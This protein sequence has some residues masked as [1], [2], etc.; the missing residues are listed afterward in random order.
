MREGRECILGSSN[1]GRPRKHKLPVNPEA[2][3]QPEPTRSSEEDESAFAGLQNPSDALG[4][5]A[6][7]ADENLESRRNSLHAQSHRSPFQQH[8][9][10]AVSYVT[11][12]QADAIPYQLCT[13]GYLT[14]RKV[15][16]LLER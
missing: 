14:T 6:Q 9:G 16:E 11:P 8:H 15:H 2:R 10:N 7:V 4:I 5:L 3:P 13:D 12:P 1:R